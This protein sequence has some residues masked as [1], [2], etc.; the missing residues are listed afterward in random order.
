MFVDQVRVILIA[1]KGGD[2]CV[3]FRREYR[4]P[5]GGPDGGRGGDGG[6]IYLVSDPNLNSLSYFRYHPINKAKKGAPGQGSN[7]QGKRGRDLYLK[8]PVGTMVKDAA[9]GQVLHDFLKPGEVYLAARGGRGGRG[10]ASFATPTHQVPREFEKGRPGEEKELILEL[11]LIADVGLVGFPNT[12]KS[13]LISKI[14]AARPEIADYPFTT[15][16]PNLGVVD[17]DEER[18]FVVADIPGLIEGAHLGHGL[19]IQFLRHIERTR[20][21]VHL[22][23][24]SPLS[25]RDPVKDYRVIQAELKA[26]NPELVS[27]K[28]VIVANKI[29]LLGEDRKRLMAVRRLAAREKKPFLAISALTGQGL[30]EL[31][32]LLAKLL[33]EM[34]N[35]PGQGGAVE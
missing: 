4:V 2:G 27:R 16:T 9:T 33:A 17:L 3:S 13:T 8:V 12:G 10:N 22:I 28:Q 21:L 1:G 25:G 29:D 19:G 35:G 18:S 15:L 34:K 31:V 24:V 26:F 14:S 5:K 6:S 23:D 30:K 11:K 7:K 20:I 32:S